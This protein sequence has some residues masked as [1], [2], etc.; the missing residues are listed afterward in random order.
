MNTSRLYILVGQH[1]VPAKDFQ[2]WSL[3]MANTDRHVAQDDIEGVRVST[4]FLGIDY[5]IPSAFFDALDE[6]QPVGD[7]NREPV[8]PI[9]FETAVFSGDDGDVSTMRRYFTWAEAQAG[10]QEVCAALRDALTE[11]GTQASVAIERVSKALKK[12]ETG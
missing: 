10:H 11:A 8:D 9:L 4:V 5:A 12:S 3:F 2:E 7:R 6:G 1:A